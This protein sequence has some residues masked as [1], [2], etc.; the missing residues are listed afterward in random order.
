VILAER[1]GTGRED[2][3]EHIVGPGHGVWISVIAAE[4]S[5]DKLPYLQRHC[6]F[7]VLSVVSYSL[8]IPKVK[9]ATCFTSM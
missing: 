9:L 3:P 7:V 4:E 6:D 2:V 5:E 1:S 8:S